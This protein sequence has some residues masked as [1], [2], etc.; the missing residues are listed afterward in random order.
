MFSL[1]RTLSFS[2]VC[3]LLISCASHPPPLNLPPN[4]EIQKQQLEEYQQWVIKGRIAYKT[5]DEAFSATLSWSESSEKTA[6]K[7]YNPLGITV[8]NIEITPT[9]STF[10]ADG[11]IYQHKNANL[12]FRQTTGWNIPVNQLRLWIKGLPSDQDKLLFNSDGTLKT[13]FPSCENC[14]N[15]RVDYV[16]FSKVNSLVLPRELTVTDT[17]RTNAFIK[18]RISSWR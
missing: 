6:L 18:L 17:S 9:Q 5:E 3:L 15:W 4:W 16:S 10:K 14:E 7:L 8:A 2:I 11:E 12:L 13:L 1:K